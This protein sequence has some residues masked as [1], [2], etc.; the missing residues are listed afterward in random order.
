MNKACRFST[1]ACR[2]EISPKI[3]KR[4]CSTYATNSKNELKHEFYEK[5]NFPYMVNELKRK[6][7]A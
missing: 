3:D 7:F 1:S 6:N 2:V 4:T 5:I